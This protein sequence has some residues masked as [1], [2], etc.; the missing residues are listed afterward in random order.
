MNPGVG[1]NFFVHAASGK[2]RSVDAEKYKCPLIEHLFAAEAAEAAEE[3]E[4]KATV[5][6]VF[7][8]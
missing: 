8:D 6:R 2:I 4:S 3:R 7:V 5:S 1:T